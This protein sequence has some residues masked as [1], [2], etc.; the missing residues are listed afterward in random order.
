MKKVT[1]CCQVRFTIAR[2]TFHTYG[3][4]VLVQCYLIPNQTELFVI[5]ME[6]LDDVQEILA[7]QNWQ[8]RKFQASCI[9]GS[10]LF[11]E[12]TQA[13]KRIPPWKYFYSLRYIIAINLLI[14]KQFNLPRFNEINWT[15]S[16]LI[17]LEYRF[18]RSANMLLYFWNWTEYC[19]L[20][21]ISWQK[22]RIF[23]HNRVS[24]NLKIFFQS[25]R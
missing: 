5:V 16:T 17:L 3:S 8:R 10:A 20:A 15:I 6:V 4:V 18:S 2:I 19:L 23:Q 7:L 25:I 21:E 24:F 9:Q 22:L 13:A 12:K 14:N 1:I 11:G